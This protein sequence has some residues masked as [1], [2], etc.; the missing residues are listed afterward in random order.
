LDF[1]FI[2]ANIRPILTS[3]P[4]EYLKTAELRGKLFEEEPR[5]PGTI[6]CIDTSFYVDHTEPLE[7]LMEFNDWPL[8]ELPEG[9]EFLILV[10]AP[11]AF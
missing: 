6:C 4:V 7:A 5:E 2:H 11:P 9:H 8:G 10:E 3:T 1:E